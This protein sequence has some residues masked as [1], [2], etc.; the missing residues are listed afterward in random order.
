MKKKNTQAITLGGI[1]TAIYA[2]VSLIS[3]YFFPSFSIVFPI[4][5]SIFCAYYATV[6]SLK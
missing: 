4:I 6:F 5:F 2:V 3:I 1:F